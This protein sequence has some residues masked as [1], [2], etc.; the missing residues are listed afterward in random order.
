MNLPKV[1]SRTVV[2][3]IW[4]FIGQDAY[5][6]RYAATVSIWVRWSC[7]SAVLVESSYRV[8]YGALSHILNTLHL[9]GLMGASGLVWLKIRAAGRVD[10]RWLL[11][12]S[13][14]DLA[15][16]AF[17]TSMSGG[18]TAGIFPCTTSQ[19][20]CPPGYSPRPTW[21]SR[22]PPWSP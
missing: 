21:P 20:R 11:A 18:S 14:L 17:T 10:P 1:S 9:L 4:G 6:L 15:G 16:L 5:E 19:W 12:L 13:A 2:Q 3:H 7:L 22:G 8:E